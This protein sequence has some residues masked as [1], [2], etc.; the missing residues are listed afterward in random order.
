M[1]EPNNLTIN[2][3]ISVNS[4]NIA[5]GVNAAAGT[6][7]TNTVAIGSQ[8][9]QTNL[10]TDSIAIGYNTSANRLGSQSTA[11][12]SYSGYNQTGSYN[13]FIGRE[14]GY[15]GGAARTGSN[16]TYIGYLAQAN[17]SNYSNSTA[18]GTGAVITASNQ[19]VLG[20]TTEQVVIKGNLY[21]KATATNQSIATFEGPGGGGST[22]NLDLCSYLNSSRIPTNRI[23]CIDDG[24]YSGHYVFYSKTPGADL[25]TLTERMRI[26]SDGTVRIPGPLRVTNPTLRRRVSTSFNILNNTNTVCQFNTEL[27][28]SN[29]GLTY[30]NGYFTNS[31]SYTV[32]V[33]VTGS[34]V[35]A[36]TGGGGTRE[37]SFQNSSLTEDFVNGLTYASS[38]IITGFSGFECG[39]CFCKTIT[40]VSSGTFGVGLWQNST[41]TMTPSIG[42]PNMIEIT[43]V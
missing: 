22:V 30:S 16:N 32:T 13:T 2:G 8:A 21:S 41:T 28:S 1:D 18:I 25:N 35:Y 23:T 38:I 14:A 19:I 17:A 11:V 29:T 34:F 7:G 31:N 10:G 26:A 27:V 12:G 37:I 43:V 42:R 24:A 6:V 36:G 33:M 9:G 5:L 40:L 20:T 15:E 39:I 4:T 3:N